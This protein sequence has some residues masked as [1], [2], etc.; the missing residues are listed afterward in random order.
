MSEGQVASAS[1]SAT[2]N[3]RSSTAL[4]FSVRAMPPPLPPSTRT[5]P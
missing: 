5:E 3:H 1:A 2:L 4:E